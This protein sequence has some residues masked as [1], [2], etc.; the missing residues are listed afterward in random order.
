MDDLIVAQQKLGILNIHLSSG[1]DIIGT[2]F[3]KSAAA[4]EQNENPLVEG[5]SVFAVQKPMIPTID[6]NP[7]NGA[8]RIGLLPL[9]PY[10]GNVE[11][12]E[13]PLSR[14]IYTLKV[15]PEMATLYA[16]FTSTVQVVP[17]SVLSNL[18]AGP[19]IRL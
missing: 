5:E 4:T 11:E 8:L 10:L 17:A 15:T 19:E 1:E 2:V 13:I 6:Q 9:R 16:R 3:F 18:P 14:V 12:V 7:Q